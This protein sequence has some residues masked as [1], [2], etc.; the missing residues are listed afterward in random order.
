MSPR[1]RLALGCL[2]GLVA[3]GCGGQARPDSDI[4]AVRASG[5]SAVDT[6]AVGWRANDKVVFTV[7]HAVQGSTGVTVDNS[8][9]S[10]VA[11]DLRTDVAVLRMPGRSKPILPGHSARVGLRLAAGERQVEVRGHLLDFA[12]GRRVST[13]V[14]AGPTRPTTIDEA[15]D[16]TTYT[17]A[18]FSIDAG[19]EPGDSGSPVVDDHGRVLGMVFA[20]SRTDPNL[21]YAVDASEIQAIVPSVG[22][23]V[24]TG[25]CR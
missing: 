4:V 3:A 22:A 6:V 20:A 5:C 17:R 19:V 12:G 14:R 10:V 9:A 24:P 8:P 21:A 15:A 7:A 16:S 2:V 18:A 1:R 13:T 25:R 23:P 11:I